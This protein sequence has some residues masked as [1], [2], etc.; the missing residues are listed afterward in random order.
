VATRRLWGLIAAAGS[1]QRLCA[2]TPKQYHHLAGRPVLAWSID[3]LLEGADLQ[4]VVVVRAADDGRFEHIEQYRDERVS[5]CIG[6]AERHE[7]VRAGLVALRE[8]GAAETDPVL[9]HDAA[10]PA[11]PA[12][13]IAR[14]IETVADDPDGGLLAAPVR[15]TLKRA[16]AAGRAVETPSRQGLWQ[17]MTPQ[18]FPLGRLQAALARGGPVTDEAQA[19]EALGARPRLVAGDPGNLKYTYPDDREA[20]VGAIERQRRGQRS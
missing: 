18:L 17:A 12:A 2:D 10:R 7:S 20:L 14:L 16:D 4:A 6:G 3:A 1:G 19:M 13:D 5:Q 15:D 9:V 8:R 11:V